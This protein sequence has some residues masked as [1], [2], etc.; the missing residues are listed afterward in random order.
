MNGWRDGGGRYKEISAPQS[1][2]YI[3]ECGPSMCD[4]ELRVF[5]NMLIHNI[6]KLSFH[7]HKSDQFFIP[8]S[9]GAAAHC[10]LS[11]KKK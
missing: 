4:G 5:R 9:S 2:V 10:T 8:D 6:E 1:L 7:F 3:P 11:K